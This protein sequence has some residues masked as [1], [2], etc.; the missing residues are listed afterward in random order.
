MRGAHFGRPR[1]RGVL[2]TKQ[3]L[4]SQTFLK[5]F[6]KFFFLLLIYKPYAFIVIATQKTKNNDHSRMHA[7]KVGNLAFPLRLKN[8]ENLNNAL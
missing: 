5:L 1:T 2:G 6:R 8:R 4:L 7:K 3:T